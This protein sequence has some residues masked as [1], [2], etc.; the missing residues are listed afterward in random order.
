[1]SDEESSFRCEDCGSVFRKAKHLRHH[2]DTVHSTERR[3]VCESCGLSYKRSSHLRRHVQNSHNAAELRCSFEGCDKIFKGPEQLKKHLKR[4]E[5]SHACEL[6][7]R[8]FSKKRQLE[9][10]CA[11]IHGPFPCAHCGR[12]FSSRTEFR[13]HVRQTHSSPS[14]EPESHTCSYC[15]EGSFESREALKLHMTDAHTNFACELC[16]STFSRE[17]DLRAHIVSKHMN[18]DNDDAHERT[19]SVCGIEFSS[20]WNLKTHIRVSHE[21]EKKFQCKICEKYFGHKHVLQRHIENVH[22]CRSSIPETPEKDFA[23]SRKRQRIDDVDHI[24]KPFTVTVGPE[25]TLS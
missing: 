22:A 9:Q 5:K 21:N 15:G 24:I 17:R 1:M 23:F 3:Y 20:A 19:C 11:K 2:I 16:P 14:K 8:S 10:H 4:H 13:L 6:C 25:D 18:E 7:G 12:I